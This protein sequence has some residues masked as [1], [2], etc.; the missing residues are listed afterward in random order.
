MN[1]NESDALGFNRRDF[2]KGGSVAT[3]MTM[4]GGVRLLGQTNA[5]DSG[6]IELKPPNAK[7]GVIGLGT[8]GR[9]IVNTLTRMNA[10]V[11]AI[12]DNYPAALSRCGR[13]APKAAQVKESQG[14][15]DDKEI[16]AVIVATPT[17][18]HKDLALL[19]L[20]AGKH[21]Y[22][23]AP[24]ANTIEDARAIA[25][26]AKTAKE[27][28]FQA[29]LQNRSDPERVFLVPFIRSGALGQIVMARAQ[30]HR[31]NSWRAAAANEARAKALNWRLDK[32]ISL[33]LEGE[34]GCHQVDEVNWFLRARP[35]AVT[36]FGS[37]ALWNK[38]NKETPD[39]REVA[40]TI[41]AVF[42]YSDGVRLTYDATL[43]NSFEAE[44]QVY[45]GS[46]A[47]VMLRD[48]K[49]WLFQETDSPQ[50]GWEIFARRDPFYKTTGIALV[51]DATKSVQKAKPVEEEPF[52]NTPLAHALENFLRNVDDFA[53]ELGQAR[54]TYKDDQEAITDQA[55]E[56]RKHLRPGASYLEGFHATVI[57]VKA[58]E[59]V[60]S[61][62]RIE[63]PRD[64]YE[65]A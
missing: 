42:E 65:L 3:L 45:Y 33:G 7:V 1:E 32:A 8:R 64:L 51:V 40:D 62:K 5:P 36:G 34:I 22:C 44:H 55:N 57:A 50:M 43:A 49:A 48:D 18:L 38:E 58:H 23:E 60:A 13:E 54:E 4:L 19:A 35:V 10:Q 20:K 39:D 17:H 15:F 11:T 27:Q 56:K 63:I 14:I 29:G 24:L 12:C 16:K 41:E 47:A 6:K 53:F 30:W 25:L 28:L 59:A 31:K 46:Y 26:A 9:E 2:L 52:K 61:G 21:V 37:I